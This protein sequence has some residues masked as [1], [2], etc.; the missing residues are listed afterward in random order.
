[1]APLTFIVESCK[2]KKIDFLKIDVEGYEFNILDSYF[3]QATAA[4]LPK[5]IY[6][7]TKS[8]HQQKLHKLLESKGYVIVWTGSEDKLFRLSPT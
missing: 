4:L 7:E 6:A 5:Y 3:E 8:D 2:L 1:M